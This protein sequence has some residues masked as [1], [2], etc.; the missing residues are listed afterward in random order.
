[1]KKVAIIGA[2]GKVG[3]LITEKAI[4]KGFDVTAIIRDASKMTDKNIPVIE[5]SVL[6]ITLSDVSDFD[7]V[8]AAY[9][10]TLGHETDLSAYAKHL[11]EIFEQANRPRLIVVGGAG[12]LYLDESRTIRRVDELEKENF[13]WF[14]TIRE[15][16]AASLIY[17]A[18]SSKADITFFSPADFFDYEGAETG[19]YTIT[20]EILEKNS[21]GISRIS[22]RDYAAA[23]VEIVASDSHH[24]RHI[25]IF[26][27]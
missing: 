27:N 22:Y 25:G 7:T 16:A 20:G 3:S 8:I 12:A 9:G 15:W 2:T 5:K 14:P 11:T 17:K 21:A 26:E 19:N 13:P 18:S 1:M 24:E 23:L 6:D 10:V 4:A